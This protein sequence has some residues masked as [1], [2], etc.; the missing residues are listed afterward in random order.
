MGLGLAYCKIVVEKMNGQIECFSKPEEG[1][2]I[3]FYITAKCS[4]HDKGLQIDE[5]NRFMNKLK[6]KVINS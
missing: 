4:H 2:L 5:Q 3:S 6:E 1:T